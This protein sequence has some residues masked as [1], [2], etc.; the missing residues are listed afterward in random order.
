MDS[1]TLTFFSLFLCQRWRFSCIQYGRN[2]DS[3][4]GNRGILVI[5]VECMEMHCSQTLKIPVDLF[6]VL[7]TGKVET[8]VYLQPL[9]CV[10]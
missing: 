4:D 3:A 6:L 5:E 2:I 9:T 1:E 7:R 10:L 8:M